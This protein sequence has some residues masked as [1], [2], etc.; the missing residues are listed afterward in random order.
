[1]FATTDEPSILHASDVRI[2]LFCNQYRVHSKRPDP[3]DRIILVGLN[4]KGRST[5][6]CSSCVPLV[7]FSTGVTVILAFNNKP[8]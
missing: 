4:V 6:K 7:S 8:Q 3:D 1:M 5:F 2:S